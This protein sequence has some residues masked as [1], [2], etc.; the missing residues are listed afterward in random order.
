LTSKLLI[1]F[2]CV[3]KI[4]F[5]FYCIVGL[6]VQKLMSQEVDED[7]PGAAQHYC[8]HCAYVFL[9]STP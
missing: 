5:I 8:V 7:K 2:A 9:T 3:F 4:A 1:A 6:Q